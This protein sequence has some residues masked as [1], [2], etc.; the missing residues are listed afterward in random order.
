MPGW[1]PVPIIYFTTRNQLS[2]SL[3]L[4][5]HLHL[6]EITL[7]AN[8]IASPQNDLPGKVSYNFR[9]DVIGS[10]IQ[11]IKMCRYFKNKALSQELASRLG[12]Y[13]E[14]GIFI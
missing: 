3:L 7:A 12:L 2:V 14:F 5:Y 1:G 11:D 4:Y 10:K 6:L 9:N 8:T 13:F